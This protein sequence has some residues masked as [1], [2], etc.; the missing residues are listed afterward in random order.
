MHFVQ[1]HLLS[2]LIF[3]GY[4]LLLCGLLLFAGFR[5]FKTSPRQPPS[6]FLVM[7]ACSVPGLVLGYGLVVL[8]WI[9]YE[10]GW[11]SAL[12]SILPGGWEDVH[13]LATTVGGSWLGIL[14]GTL[15]GGWLWKRRLH[16]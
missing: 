4:L 9:C 14:I 1:E 10:K 2:I 5:K 15:T 7:A 12:Y 11:L 3:G 13:L 6:L 8:Y 16:P